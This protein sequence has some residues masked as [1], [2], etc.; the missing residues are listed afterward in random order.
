MLM[1]QVH[2]SAQIM[3]NEDKESEEKVEQLKT[4]R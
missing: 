2:D 3:Q 1:S 4:S